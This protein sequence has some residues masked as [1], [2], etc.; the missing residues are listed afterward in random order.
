MDIGTCCPPQ[1]IKMVRVC[2]CG[3]LIAT[4]LAT[5]LHNEPQ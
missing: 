3:S 4:L 5:H 2:V 1:P